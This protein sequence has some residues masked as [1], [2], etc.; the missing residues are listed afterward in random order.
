MICGGCFKPSP[1]PAIR[2][3]HVR[4]LSLLA[5]FDYNYNI[6]RE[7]LTCRIL[8]LP[9]P[10]L[11]YAHLSVDFHPLGMLNGMRV[12]TECHALESG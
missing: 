7:I 2:S 10:P 9:H 1:S 3:K 4:P 5:E 8:L 12:F 6:I 11:P